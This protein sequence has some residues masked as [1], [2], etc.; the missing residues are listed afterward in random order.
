MLRY[1]SDAR[2]GW[3][4]LTVLRFC[5]STG[6]GSAQELGR[7]LAGHFDKPGLLAERTPRALPQWRF[8]LLDY[9]PFADSQQQEGMSAERKISF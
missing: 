1:K 5:S 6:A 4:M 2:A 8:F 7:V 3:C 9:L